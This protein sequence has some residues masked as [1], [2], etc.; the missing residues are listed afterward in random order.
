MEQDFSLSKIDLSQD[1]EVNYSDRGIS[2]QTGEDLSTKRFFSFF[3]GFSGRKKFFFA[4]VIVFLVFFFYLGT[5]VF[6]IFSRSQ[7]FYRTLSSFKSSLSSKN[8]GEIEK[9]LEASKASLFSLNKTFNL[10]RWM[11]FVPLVGAYFADFERVLKASSYSFE[12]VDMSLGAFGGYLDLLGFNTGSSSGT[13]VDRISFITK[14]LP[15]VLP[16]TS[17]IIEKLELVESEISQIDPKRYPVRL[18]KVVVRKKMEDVL[19]EARYILTSLK[20]SEPFIQQL[21]YVLGIDSPRNYLIIFQNDKELRPT[22]GFI[23]AYSLLKIDKATFNTVRSDDIYN[24]DS[25][26]K[27]TKPA[28][29]PIVKYIKGPYS[30]SPK[31]RLRDMNWYVGFDD[32]MD[33]FAEEI[34]KLGFDNIDGIVAVDTHI[35]VDI[36]N[37]LGPIDVAGYGR[38]SNEIVPECNCPQIIY[39]LESFADVE[40]PIVWDPAGT[41]KIVYAPPN[42]ENRKKIIGPLMNTIAAY[43]LGQPAEKISDLFLVFLKAWK[44]RHILFYFN[45]DEV[46]K[47]AK[48]F[49]ITGSVADF[50]GDY[51]LIND[52]N[53][54]GRKSNLYVTQEVSQEIKVKE[55]GNLEK[56]LTI[57]YKNPEK[58]DGWLN[59]VLPNWVR[60]YVPKGSKLISIDGLIDNVEPYEEYGKTVFAGF[61]ELRPQGIV[62]VEVKYEIP[63]GKDGYRLYV[64]KQPGK[65]AF[66]YTAKF[67]K[68]VEE[69]YLDADKILDFSK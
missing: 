47:T 4:L 2:R 35:L 8:L 69:F 11:K 37:I 24:L 42:W 63:F 39:E 54:G 55:N 40:G 10:V 67:D 57:T 22:G 61:F 60:I 32:S 17:G 7:T 12:A 46:Q 28:P 52:A 23:T 9:N 20:E 3:S 18:G 66:L 30:I 34:R 59:S 27:P 16:K 64:Q 53:L 45:D 19:D 25:K 13:T 65:P 62:K 14:A 44:G 1:Q 41:G 26:Y 33:L 43:S 50:D 29:E 36:L 58:H 6:L 21:P 38:F 31:W 51:L 49:G 15:E 48:S 56:T 5:S 68:R